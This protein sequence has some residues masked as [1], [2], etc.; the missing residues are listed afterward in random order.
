M[1]FD[2]LRLTPI[3]TIAKWENATKPLLALDRGQTLL[4]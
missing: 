4:M 3:Y 2:L 1:F